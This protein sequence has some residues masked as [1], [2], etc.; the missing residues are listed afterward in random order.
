MIFMTI[1]GIGKITWASIP[2]K[3]DI[4]VRIV[5]YIK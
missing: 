5:L 3:N 2:K 4:T 1:A